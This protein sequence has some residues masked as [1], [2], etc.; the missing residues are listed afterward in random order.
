MVPHNSVVRERRL[1][2][3]PVRWAKMRLWQRVWQGV[4]FQVVPDIDTYIQKKLPGQSV[5]TTP[6]FDTWESFSFSSLKNITRGWHS[7]GWRAKHI[8]HDISEV[9]YSDISKVR[10]FDISKLSIRYPTLLTQAAVIK[11]LAVDRYV[12]A[13]HSECVFRAYRI[14]CDDM[15]LRCLLCLLNHKSTAVRSG[16]STVA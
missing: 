5:C 16:I 7:R 11:P 2:R 8:R 3:K 10:Y 15:A 13:T 14:Q 4:F 6:K 12:G 1:T 9:R